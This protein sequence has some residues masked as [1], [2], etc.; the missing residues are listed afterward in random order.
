MASACPELA[1]LD[2]AHLPLVTV[3][4]RQNDDI[5]LWQQRRGGGCVASIYVCMHAARLSIMNATRLSASDLRT[6]SPCTIG[7]MRC[8]TIVFTTNSISIIRSSRYS[9]YPGRPSGSTGELL[10]PGDGSTRVRVPADCIQGAFFVLFSYS[11]AGSASK[12]G[13]TT[14]RMNAG[15]LRESLS[16]PP[17]ALSEPPCVRII[18]GMNPWLRFTRAA[19]KAS[20]SVSLKRDETCSKKKTTRSRQDGARVVRLLVEIKR[21]PATLLFFFF[22][23]EVVLLLA[24]VGLSDNYF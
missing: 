10:V 1:S 8:S 14:Y 2:L 23:S 11:V 15:A 22:L 21:W 3:S 5:L 7:A 13:C 19:Q 12:Q 9:A 6:P 20:C 4:G 16:E 17:C 24:D 18:R